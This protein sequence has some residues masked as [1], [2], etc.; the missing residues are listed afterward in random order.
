M[1]VQPRNAVHRQEERA[2]FAR[3]AREHSPAARD[4]IAE[5]FLPMARQLARR[6]RDV[7]DI[8]DLEQIAA[9]GL[10]KAIDR[11][12]P[13]R[14]LAFSTFAL[15]T[16]LGE[17]KRHLRDRGW[18]VRV[19]RDVRELAARLHSLSNEL[20]PQ[21]GRFPTAAELAKHTRPRRNGS[22]TR[23]R[24]A[25]PAE[26]CHSINHTMRTNPKPRGSRSRSTNSASAQP[27]TQPFWL[28]CSG[29]LSARERQIVCL[30]FKEDLT[31][32][33]IGEI[34]GLSQMHVS[35]VLRTSLERLQTAAL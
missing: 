17:L 2:L 7:E 30:R 22:S 33:E 32:R 3:L 34:I 35:R 11:F 25:P 29:E 15:P 4:A 20:L 5:R 1:T 19:P 9:V 27:K 14:G 28:A 12:D 16:I 10:V 23:C 31:Q 8:D 13:E 6:Y 21:L 24:R 26:P 18:A